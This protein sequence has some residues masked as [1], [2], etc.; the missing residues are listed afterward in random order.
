MPNDLRTTMA[1]ICSL[2][3]SQRLT[4]A[5]GGNISAKLPDGTCLVTPSRRHKRRVEEKDLVRISGEGEVLE[6]ARVPTSE[7]PMHLAI[8]RAI[9]EAGAII[10][11]HPP[12]AT[13]FALAC[14]E[15]ET[16]SSSE[17][18]F[19]LGSRVPLIGYAR[20]S[21]D[22]LG[23]VVSQAMT[24]NHKACLMANHGVITWGSDLWDAFDVLDTLE[25]FAH[26]LFVATMMGGAVSLS[27]EELRWLAGK[28]QRAIDE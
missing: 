23:E 8:Y 19:V 24:K 2:I 9:P 6:G 15:I 20:P 14:R 1:D 12:Y 13:G 27:E 17:A 18:V 3:A 5:T 4:S 26:S 21:T 25:L 11:A 28:A 16:D 7:A 22:D 10:H